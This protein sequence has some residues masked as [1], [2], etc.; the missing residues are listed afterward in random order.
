MKTIK[1][2]LAVIL[3][4]MMLLSSFAF[5]SFAKT[6]T[7]K[8]QEYD[9]YVTTY[10]LRDEIKTGKNTFT[11][12]GNSAHLFTASKEG[13]YSVNFSVKMKDDSD[14]GYSYM[15]SESVG[16]G[17]AT[18]Y[19]ESYMSEKYGNVYYFKKGQQRY[20][21]VVMEGTFTNYTVTVTYLG[22]ATSV[23]LKDSKTPLQG[24]V[25]I[26]H[27]EENGKHYYYFEREMLFKTDS[28]KK[29]YISGLNVPTTAKSLKSGKL[30]ATVNTFG[31]KKSIS[32]SV[33]FAKDEIKSISKAKG[34]VA[35]TVSM[36]KDGSIAEYSIEE[37]ALKVAVKLKDGTT[38]QNEGASECA[39]KVTLKDGKKVVLYPSIEIK[40]GKPYLVATDGQDSEF[41]IAAAKKKTVTSED[42]PDEPTE[43]SIK[44][45]FEKVY[46]F[47][48]DIFKKF[49]FFIFAD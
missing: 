38:V 43:F 1:K 41:T 31:I 46:T 19:A 47:F 32:F 22:K 16:S 25:E 23:S 42:E 10:N 3:C 17:K 9:D 8:W 7:I 49:L 14:C 21:G 11:Y 33:F 48:S 37:S 36:Y 24:N 13:I 12:K 28:D 18:G 29:I 15:L 26:F 4:G 6:K 39:V 27:S 34:F 30:T 44:A 20:V 40:N 35:P 2:M 45:L 5:C